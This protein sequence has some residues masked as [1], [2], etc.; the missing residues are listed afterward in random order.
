MRNDRK[1]AGTP[2]SRG[3]ENLAWE[4]FHE[5]S[6]ISM[7]ETPPSDHEVLLRMADLDESLSF[8]GYPIVE[9]A[10]VSNL[11]IPL[12]EAIQNRST[13]KRMTPV[14]VDLRT[15]S[16]LLGCAY[17]V[18]HDQRSLGYP[19]AFRA[20]PSGGALYPLE[21]YFQC[22]HALGFSSGLYHYNPFKNHLRLLRCG[23]QSETIARCL[24]QQN[25]AH[26]SSLI[27]FITA[28]FDRSTFKYGDRGYRFALLE[29][30][31]VAQNL[32]L[33]ALGL[34]LGS[35]NIGGFYDRRID[36]FLGLDGLTH[37]TVYMI[38]I[39]KEAA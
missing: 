14:P 27:I 4:V 16:T 24:V 8:E 39:G 9:M 36:T 12:G 19:R 31:H 23:D 15:V 11:A 20:T 37:S 30:G 1:F 26:D 38:A 34:G 22:G 10:E 7:F 3:D 28:L 25:I 33:S 17:G 35:M 29:A 21:I 13:A 2:M 6:K 32:N 18:T 5:N